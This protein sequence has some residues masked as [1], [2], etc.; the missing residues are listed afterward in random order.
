YLYD[1]SRMSLEESYPS[2]IATV[3]KGDGESVLVLKDA[4][5][6]YEIRFHIDTAKRAVT[7]AEHFNNSKLSSKTTYADFVEVGGSWWP[8][9]METTGPDGHPSVRIS[10]TVTALS[11]DDF[12]A[13][14][15]QAVAGRDAV[16]FLRSPEPTVAAAKKANAA[17]KAGFDER[18]AL[19]NHY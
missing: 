4:A 19:L 2:M 17:S 16:P 15:K 7:K 5:K 3:Q 12:N 14:V 6:Q 18:F 9:Q 8:R 11:A 13:Q 1:H 10:Q